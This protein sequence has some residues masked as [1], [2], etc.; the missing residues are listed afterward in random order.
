MNK[1][2]PIAIFDSGMGGLSVF[3]EIETLMPHENLIY[4]GDTAR[5]PYGTRSAETI[6]KFVKSDLDFLAQFAPKH[7]VVACGTASSVGN[8]V[9]KRECEHFTSVINPSAIAAT[10]ATKNGK[11]GVISTTATL[12][13]GAFERKI[14]KMLPSATV[15]GKAAPLFV[16]LV[17]NGFTD[18][19]DE[20][21]NA[22]A[23]KYL[24]ELK[25][26]N[27]DTL[28]LGCTHFPLL[29]K[30]IA[31]QMGEGVTLISSGYETALATKMDLEALDL[32]N[33]SDAPGT[34]RFFVSDDTDAFCEQGAIFLK[35][36]VNRDEVKLVEMN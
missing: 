24:K 35:H 18:E 20:A 23:K 12:K 21:A 16:N 29:S 15:Y 9:L 3:R 1:N 30:V 11:I 26:K 4:F 22:V 14:K 32:L 25:E 33:E 28:I 13:S 7:I 8:K 10:K 36:P 2:A 27:I 34:K 19:N 31:K 6:E 17:E 5:V